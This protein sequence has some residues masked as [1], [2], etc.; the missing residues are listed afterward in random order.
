M[1]DS[2]KVTVIRDRKALE[3]VPVQVP[4]SRPMLVGV[5]ALGVRSRNPTEDPSHEAVLR[6]TG[7]RVP[8]I[9]HQ[10]KRTQLHCIALEP[11]AQHANK[12][13]KILVLVQNCLP[14]IFAIQSMV[15]QTA[16]ISASFVWA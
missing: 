12:R 9:C 13:L 1:A 10:R 4:F 15:N 11:F 14:C 6:W 5:V 16:L 7:K 8:V 3:A 2:Q